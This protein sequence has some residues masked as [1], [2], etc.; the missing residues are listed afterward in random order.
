M[1]TKVGR[2]NKLERVVDS[3]ETGLYK[4]LNAIGQ[5]EYFGKAKIKG[6]LKQINLTK[7]Y[8]ATSK[9]KAEQKLKEWKVG[10]GQLNPSDLS[11]TKRTR[12]NTLDFMFLEDYI[13]NHKNISIAKRYKG[14]YLKYI[15]KE[16][17]L[18]KYDEVDNED[19]QKL[20]DKHE[21]LDD[22]S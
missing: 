11:N 16:I 12:F 18:K 22:M 15:Q 13:S 2:K 7:K 10:L 19:L 9:S 4:S 3:K 8:G 5:L 6:N 17:G 20:I 14:F 21:R 1:A